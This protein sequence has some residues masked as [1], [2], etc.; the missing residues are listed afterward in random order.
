MKTVMRMVGGRVQKATLYAFFLRR[1]N[2][3]RTQKSSAPPAAARM[4]DM[5]HDVTMEITPLKGKASME[6]SL[7]AQMTA[8][9]PS[10]IKEKATIPPTAVQCDSV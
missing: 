2:D 8:S 9:L 4:G 1:T 7:S 6:L 3:L 10:Q 5:I